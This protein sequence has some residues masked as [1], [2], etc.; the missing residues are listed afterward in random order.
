[1]PV[2]KYPPA[3]LSAPRTLPMNPALPT[4]ASLGP[5]EL[6]RMRELVDAKTKPRGSLG[7]LETL[8][9]QIGA[10]QRSQTPSIQRP[11][12]IVCA[13]DHG[14]ARQGVSA[15]P[16]SV[17]AQM[18][19]NFL[20][21]GAAI[22]AFCAASDITLEIVNAGVAEPVPDHPALIDAELAGASQDFSRQPAMTVEQAQAAFFAGVARVEFHHAAGSNTVACGEM[23][24]GNTSAA[25]C[26]MS[27]F[28]TL[29]IEACVGRGTGLDEAG[30][31]HK[32][33]VL[34]Q[35]LELHPRSADPWQTLATFG[36]PEIAMMAG[37]FVGAAALRMVVVIDGFIAGAALLAAHALR[38]EVIEYCVF[39]HESDEAGHR[40]LLA[41]LGVQPL[42][43]LGLRLGEGSG[44]ALAIP[45]LRAACAF[46][47]QM[48]S[49]GSAGVDTA[50]PA[51]HS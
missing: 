46:T 10:I 8:A 11:V 18:V 41:H 24:I 32:L 37:A 13:A 45:L 22:N 15:Y 14:I 25:A 30:L 23:G 51:T 12:M 35:A 16:Q 47:V 48:A 44:A 7:Q 1:M 20:A 42:L 27:R 5:H 31:A 28:C 43:R 6:A 9:C 3:V 19:A 50:L 29:P 17:T 38:P 36:G 40:A 49:F 33:Q 39:A 26:L 34:R 21:G 4:I 2:R